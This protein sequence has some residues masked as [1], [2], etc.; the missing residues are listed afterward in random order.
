MNTVF[1]AAAS[2]AFEIVTE[3]NKKEERKKTRCV[4][5]CLVDI[6]N[7]VKLK[8]GKIMLRARKI[9]LCH[10]EKCRE[11]NFFFFHDSV[12]TQGFL[13]RRA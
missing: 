3:K 5:N 4:E 11:F 7:A 8:C 10:L 2:C 1:P 9:T 12:A 13:R 6:I